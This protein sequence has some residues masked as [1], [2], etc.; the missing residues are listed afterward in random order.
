MIT[1]GFLLIIRDNLEEGNALA[2]YSAS[3]MADGLFWS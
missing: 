2:V 3:S 1:G